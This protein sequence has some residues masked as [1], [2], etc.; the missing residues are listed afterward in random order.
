MK[1]QDSLGLSGFM[2]DAIKNP[3][4][5]GGPGLISGINQNPG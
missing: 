5:L 4:S 2:H 1:R 3:V